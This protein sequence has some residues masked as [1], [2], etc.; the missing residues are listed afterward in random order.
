MIVIIDY[1][2]GNIGSLQ[3]MIKKAGGTSTISSNARDIENAEKLIL[4][5]VGAFDNGMTNLQKLGLINVLNKKAVVEKTPI[6][7]VCLGMQLLT[8]SSEEGVLS[9]LGWL[10]AK[11][12]KFKFT[13][14]S[15]KLKLP[16]M[17]W[18]T[19]TIRKESLLF[20]GMYEDARFYFVHSYHLVC[21]DESDILTTTN[22]GYDFVSAVEKG[23]IFG[24]QF[25]P[26]KSHKYGLKLIKNFLE[27][28]K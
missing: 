15:K 26:E 7:G 8:K 14:D 27:L 2:M 21:E 25:H 16:H 18:N 9:G 23:N 22:Y 12:V 17:G 1:G 4:P 6:L 19:I 3:N 10:N 28:V 5:G 20:N 11:T 13:G 24:V